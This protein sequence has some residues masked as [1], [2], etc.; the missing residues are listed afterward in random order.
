M[1]EVAGI[2]ETKELVVALG[3]IGP[4]LVKVLKDG[5]QATDAIALYNEIVAN[6]AV[7]DAVLAAVD[8]IKLIPSELKDLSAVEIGELTVLGVQ[9]TIELIKAIKAPV[10]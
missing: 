5:V 1:A 10:A 9:N 7:K 4:V 2:K 3:A 8:G 6:P